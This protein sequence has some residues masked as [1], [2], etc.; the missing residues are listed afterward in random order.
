MTANPATGLTGGRYTLPAEL[1]G[2]EVE[3]TWDESAKAGYLHLRTDRLVDQT[4]EVSPSVAV[5]VADGKLIGVETIGRPVDILALAEVLL[6][7][8]PVELIDEV[9]QDGWPSHDR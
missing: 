9:P 5:D 1:G 2:G 8:G 3:I 7:L 4:I 6:K